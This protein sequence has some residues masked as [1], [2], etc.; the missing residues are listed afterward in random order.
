MIDQIL[1]LFLI[2][3]LK[4]IFSSADTAFTYI[5]RAE[6]NQA[7]KTDKK[8]KKIKELMEDSNKFF[9][10]IEVG[11]NMSELLASA[12]VSITFLEQFADILEKFRLPTNIAILISVIVMTIILAYIML[13]F[14]AIL[15]KR[16]ARNHPK[17]VAYK[18]LPIITFVAKINHP[19]E[20]LIDFSTD[21]FSK[22][23]KIKEE[24]EEKLTEKQLKMIIR[25]AKD[26]GVIL[27]REKNILINTLKA[28]DTAINK[29]MLPL[30]K[31]GM[32]DIEAGLEDIIADIKEY[33]YSRIPIYKQTKDKI[34]GILNIKD[35]AIQYPEKGIKKKSELKKILRKV[36][37]IEEKE[38]L[39]IA[40]KKMQKERNMMAIV[41]DK[42][43]IPIGLV[44]IEDILE[45]LVGKIFDEND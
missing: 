39:F 20:R 3:I 33:K 15:P 34:V 29:I 11:I 37:T 25:E 41:V 1:I 13:V 22:I 5:N 18:L 14:G 10:V 30:E 23:F 36:Q 9:G 31:A 2:V 43:E 24:P 45:K 42:N 21:K 32:I 19:F 8:E 26:E 7:S 27:N 6:I 44:T 17:K 12:W 28:N 35:I 4:A 40:F 38:K 16:I